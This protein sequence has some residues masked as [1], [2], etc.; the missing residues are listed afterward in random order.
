SRRVA[1][2]A[3]DRPGLRPDSWVAALDQRFGA[4]EFRV[5][6]RQGVA[7]RERRGRRLLHDERITREPLPGTRQA[8]PVQCHTREANPPGRPWSARFGMPERCRTAPAPTPWRS[9]RTRRCPTRQTWTP[10]P[11]RARAGAPSAPPGRTRRTRTCDRASGRPRTPGA[12]APSTAAASD[13]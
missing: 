13:G 2:R 6:R 11:R 1:L 10:R 4:E 7:R 9:S 12:A 3:D 8:K 5:A